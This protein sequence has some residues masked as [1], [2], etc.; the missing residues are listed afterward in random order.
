[1]LTMT[2]D[3]LGVELLEC[4]LYVDRDTVYN[5]EE[6]I[7]NKLVELE[8]I[9]EVDTSTSD[10]TKSAT[11]KYKLTTKVIAMLDTVQ[12]YRYLKLVDNRL[13]YLDLA[14]TAVLLAHTGQGKV[15]FDYNGIHYTVR[16]GTKYNFFEEQYRLRNKL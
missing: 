7:A 10:I 12:K 1:M 14:K 15:E 8:F 11:L 16:T 6:Y 5:V 3:I 13:G 4:R 2:F 9:Q